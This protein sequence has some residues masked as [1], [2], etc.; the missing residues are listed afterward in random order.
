MVAGVVESYHDVHGTHCSC[1]LG[2][3]QSREQFSEYFHR[4]FVQT[5]GDTI[6]PIGEDVVL[7]SF[8]NHD[9]ELVEG[10]LPFFYLVTSR[11]HQ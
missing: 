2:R 11:L 10:S 7:L 1:Y 3:I 8:A 4:Y 9:L 5:V 6:H